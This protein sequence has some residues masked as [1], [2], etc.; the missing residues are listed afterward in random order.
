MMLIT[1]RVFRSLGTSCDFQIL[2]NKFNNPS[3]KQRPQ[4]LSSSTHVIHTWG[5]PFFFPL[6]SL[7][8][9]QDLLSSSFCVCRSTDSVIFFL[10]V[11]G[12]VFLPYGSKCFSQP[13]FGIKFILNW[14]FYCFKI[15][16][17]S[18]ASSL[19][20]NDSVFHCVTNLFQS[21]Q[22]IFLESSLTLA[23]SVLCS[24]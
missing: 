18:K 22:L 21:S 3:F 24:T 17:H 8:L 19:W 2:L 10:A 1:N 9:L 12:L 13:S 11:S 23:R 4:F 15:S 16:E 20:S 6:T 14:S 7:K 5:F